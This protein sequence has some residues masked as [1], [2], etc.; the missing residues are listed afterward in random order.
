MQ[1]AAPR[2]G[3]DRQHRAAPVLGVPDCHDPGHAAAYLDT[4]GL[5]VAVTALLP[6][7]LRV[8]CGAHGSISL[9]A[10]VI[11]SLDALSLSAHSH[12]SLKAISYRSISPGLSR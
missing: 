12:I 9:T 8:I 4:V 1:Q 6:R 5:P 11:S 7:A 2:A 3:R 10:S